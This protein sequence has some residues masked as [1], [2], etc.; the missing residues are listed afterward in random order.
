MARAALISLQIG[1]QLIMVEYEK[2]PTKLGEIVLSRTA[3]LT[4]I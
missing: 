3:I 4:Q 1:T 2:I